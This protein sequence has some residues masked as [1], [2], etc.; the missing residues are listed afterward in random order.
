MNQPPE[1]ARKL[2]T[3]GASSDNQETR[4][5]S[6]DLIQDY[7]SGSKQIDNG[8]DRIDAVFVIVDFIQRDTT[9]CVERDDVV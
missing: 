6:T 8:F 1:I 9:A 4:D 2:D 5:L 7:F 3:R